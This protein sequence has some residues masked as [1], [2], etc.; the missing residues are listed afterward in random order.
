MNMMMDLYYIPQNY[1]VND[2]KHIQNKSEGLDLLKYYIKT[3][4]HIDFIP[5][6]FPYFRMKIYI[7]LS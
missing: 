5:D 3:Q 7:S 6:R 1:R 4:K 2:Q